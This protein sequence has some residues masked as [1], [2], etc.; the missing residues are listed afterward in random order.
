MA[1][2][3]TKPA[4]D[5]LIEKLIGVNRVSKVVKGGRLF[6]FAALVVVGDGNGRV[7]QQNFMPM[8]NRTNAGL[9]IRSS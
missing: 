1:N 4:G 5:E 8:M 2:Y 6:G 3:E 7:V 9:A